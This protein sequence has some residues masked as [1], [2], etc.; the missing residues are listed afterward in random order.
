VRGDGKDGY[1]KGR[2]S[3]VGGRELLAYTGGA[4]VLHPDK[5]LHENS[6]KKTP[7]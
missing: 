1:F 2:S 7:F 3:A 5:R 6:N 4:K